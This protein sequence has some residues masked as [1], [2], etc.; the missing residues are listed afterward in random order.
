MKIKLFFLLV[1]VLMLSI[2]STSMIPTVASNTNKTS[3]EVEKATSS[4]WTA[5]DNL[6][7]T[8]ADNTQTGNVKQD[9]YVGLFYW[10]W[11]DSGWRESELAVNNSTIIEAFNDENMWRDATHPAWSWEYMNHSWHEPVYGYYLSTDTWVLR[12]HAEVLAD[13][14]VDVIFFDCSN[15]THLFDNSLDAIFRTFQQAYDDGVNVPKISFLL[16]FGSNDARR[17]QLENLYS[18]YYREGLYSDTWFIYEGKPLILGDTTFSSSYEYYDEIK[19][20]FNF[21]VMDSSYT[22]ITNPA[23]WTW[24]NLY[25][26]H[27]AYRREDK[28]RVPEQISVSVAMNCNHQGGLSASNAGTG[29]VNGRTYTVQNG[30]DTRVNAVEYGAHFAEQ[31]EY[32]IEQDPEFIFIT[33]WNE[34][35]AMR[36]PEW[37]GT[38]N[39]FAD[40]FSVEFSRDIEFSKTQLKDS[41]YYQMVDYIRKFKGTEPAPTASEP[42]VIDINSEKDMWADVS[43][44]YI[45]YQGNTFDRDCDGYGGLHYYN[46][47]GRNDIISA[48][49][50][51]DS[52]N[53]YFMVETKD[54]LSPRSD[55]AWMRLLIDVDNSE[56]NWETFEYIVNRESPTDMAVLERSTGG[57]NWETV[58]EVYYSIKG[59]RLQIKIPK[60][61]LGIDGNAFSLNFKWSDNMQNDGD[62]MDFYINGDVAPSGR[63][64]YRFICE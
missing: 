61:M 52:E 27:I 35:V 38:V 40:Q 1:I 8:I 44:E 22:N 49:V 58:G 34:R 4:T 19:D 33:G 47:T 32:A 5:T 39:G 15:D 17:T 3:T 11:H 60:A 6:G 24:S 31:F 18:R 62:I 57:W 37:C 29:Q 10:N 59:N 43:P 42:K 16:N 64:K 50:A 21:R 12:K 45:A 14:G 41:Y 26:Q 13:A 53:I 51:R 48:K 23:A 63:F 55:D 25:P 54:D 7:R 46:T 36:F 56:N 30:Y 2:F 28:K 9:K 20:F